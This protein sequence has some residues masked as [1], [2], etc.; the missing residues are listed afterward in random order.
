MEYL[1]TV[2]FTE[3]N[4]PEEVFTNLN[5]KLK[6][7]KIVLIRGIDVE[8]SKLE[9]FY[10]RLTNHIGG[11]QVETEDGRKNRKEE[12]K[13]LEVQF[14]P[15][16]KGA[17]RHSSNAQPL[18]TDFSYINSAPNFTL[19]YCK[20]RAPEG[21][22][23]VFIDGS[24]LVELMR[25]EE[26]VLLKRLLS[27][28]IRFAKVFENAV[29]TR[30]E[31]PIKKLDDHRGYQLNWNY[32]CIDQNES[33]EVKA[34]VE[35]FHLYLNSK[36]MNTDR[37]TKGELNRGDAVIWHDDLVLHGRNSFKAE[38]FGDRN[39]WKTSIH[40]GEPA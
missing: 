1:A 17:Y 13:W 10:D 12:G 28:R 24:S 6:N 37:V 35:E 30:S 11:C 19:M 4:T 21:G 38:K 7:Y 23:T 39:L 36:I 15:S 18:H 20:K 32:H 34:L 5:E 27:T 33:S 3:V 8:D 31:Y 22:E 14:D 26:P 16:I 29:D 25:E 9:Y 40:W 2:Q